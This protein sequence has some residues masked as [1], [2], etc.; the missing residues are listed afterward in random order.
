MVQPDVLNVLATNVQS[1]R[2]ILQRC[3]PS[4]LLTVHGHVDSPLLHLRLAR[5]R[6]SR[7]ED[8][9][10]LQRISEACLQHSVAIPRSRYVDGEK[11]Q[12]PPSLRICVSAMHTEDIMEKAVGVLAEQASKVLNEV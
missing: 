11:Y 1:V 6:G 12:P 8:T 7:G 4:S 10:L 5:S 2:R 9:R 3:L